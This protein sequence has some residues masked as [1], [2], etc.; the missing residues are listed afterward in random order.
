L[1]FINIY[2]HYLSSKRGGNKPF[3]TPSG[4]SAPQVGD[5]HPELSA[6]QTALTTPIPDPDYMHECIAAFPALKTLGCKGY[7]CPN[8]QNFRVLE[9]WREIVGC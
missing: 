3:P 5:S 2:Q 6:L 4:I 8:L 7:S 9:F 1:Q